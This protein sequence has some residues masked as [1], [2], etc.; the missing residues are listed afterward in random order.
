[1]ITVVGLVGLFA[2]CFFMPGYKGGGFVCYYPTIV[3]YSVIG[4]GVIVCAASGML[5]VMGRRYP[6]TKSEES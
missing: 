3:P 2:D 1:M 4:I 6:A 5:L